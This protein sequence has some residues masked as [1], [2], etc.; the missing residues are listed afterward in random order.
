MGKA[1]FR[2]LPE[3]RMHKKNHWESISQGIVGER[4]L[5]EWSEVEANKEPFVI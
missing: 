5:A 2:M 4:W 1:K 3:G